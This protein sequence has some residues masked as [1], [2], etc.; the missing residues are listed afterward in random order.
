MIPVKLSLRNFMPYRDNVPPLYFNGIHIACIS[1]D[2]GNGKSALIDAMTWALWGKTRN[3]SKSDDPLIHQ[4]QNEMEVEFDF[5]VDKQSY[6]IIRKHARPRRGSRTGKTLLDFQIA[7]NDGF[8]SISADSITQ[9]QQKV[10]NILHMDYATFINSAFLRQGHADEFTNQPPTK[11]KEVLGN[12]LGLAFYDEL[13]QRAKELAKEQEAEGRQLESALEEINRE[14]AQK[15]AYE[16]EL[17]QAQAAL[18]QVEKSLAEHETRLAKLKKDK[19][20]LENKKQQLTQL[21]EHTAATRRELER[22]EQEVAQYQARIKEHEAVIAQRPA[23]EEGYARLAEA[24]K[25][26]EELNQKLGLLVKLKEKRSQLE[27]AIERAQA[28]LI[29]EHK[30][31]QSKIAELEATS[32]KLPQLKNEL[33]QA[34]ARLHQLA[35]QEKEL[36]SK[37]QASQELR[38]QINYL[39]SSRTSLEREIAEI[40]ENI[41]ILS[42]HA[43]TKCPLCE[44]ELGEDG[45]KRIQD[46]YTAERESKSKALASNQAELANKKKELSTLEGELSPL[47]TKLG[48]DKASAQTKVSL[49][50]QSISEV[51]AVDSQLNQ[52][53]EKLNEIEQSLAG[54]DFAAEEQQA[55]AQVERE[56]DRLDYDSPQHEQLRQRLVELEKYES[57]KRKLE[58]AD[59]LLR[60]EKE[61]AAKAEEASRELRQRLEADT[62]KGQDLN[63]ELAALPQLTTDLTQAESEHQTLAAQQ[64]QAQELMWGVKSKLERCSELEIRKGEKEKLLGQASKEEKIYKDLAQAFGKKGIQALIIEMALPEIEAEANRLL[65]RMTDNRMHV[66]METQRQTRKGETVE[67]LDINIADELGTRNYEMFSGGEA[68]RIDFAVRIALSKLLARRAGAPLPTLIIDEGFGTQDSSGIEKLKEAINSIKDDFDKILVITHM[69]E[70]RDAFPTRINVAKTAQGS[71]VELS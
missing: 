19:E 5:A 45:L 4:G 40:T 42:T 56:L 35:E 66:K 16:A 59:R 41:K 68:F 69:E 44:T 46:N 52:A 38:T 18:T 55:L 63:Q 17:E 47:E 6:R 31:A 57:P 8:K 61:A 22:R 20:A 36:G 48:Q 21:E 28:A 49:L 3:T 14:L 64:K 71:T 50:N 25:Q 24:R 26:N 7:T 33:Q 34:E 15:P 54:K 53:R 43:E 51:Q 1:G 30:L 23:I 67:T 39:S 13:E 11:R 32:Q 12:I 65:G 9:T 29:T 62:K 60:Q 37:K 10:I 58:E 27:L 70:L 2:N